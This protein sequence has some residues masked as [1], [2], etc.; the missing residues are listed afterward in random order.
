MKSVKTAKISIITPVYNSE[1]YLKDCVN[2]VLSQT[3]KDFELVL[4]NDGSTDQSGEICDSFAKEDKRIKV[5][6]KKNEGP[7]AARK[8]GAME[9]SGEYITFLDSDDLLKSCLLEKLMEYI[10]NHNPDAI[11]FGYDRFGE[12][13]QEN[14]STIPL[15]EEGLYSGDNLKE[16]KNNLIY[17]D[18]DILT[19]PYGV[20]G[21]VFRREDYIKYQD[22]VIKELYKGEDLAV[23]APL[24][25]NC[26]RVYVSHLCGYLYRDTPGS[27]MNSFKEDEPQQMFLLADYLSEC[28]DKKYER[29]IGVYVVTHIF[30]YLDR[31]IL[32]VKSYS[33]YIK[34]AKVFNTKEFSRYLISAKFQNPDIK[35][36]IIFF[37]AKHRLYL[38]IW[39]LR[40]VIKRREF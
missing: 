13:T 22:R 10:T 12:A 1:K 25:A 29:K 36:R 8:Q 2:S 23:N 7:T 3:F 26:K 18:R 4:V 15:L 14:E 34:I 27:I 33:D 9:S 37:L 6:H 19:I 28:L 24:L 30:D 39:V 21:K 17:S 31:A 32:N 40:K 35:D 5:I 38:L 11:I 16:I 20:W